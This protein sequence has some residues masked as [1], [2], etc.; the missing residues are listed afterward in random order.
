[1][2]IELRKL[3]NDLINTLHNSTACIEGK[4]VI[5]ELLAKECELKANEIISNQLQIITEKGEM[6][7]GT[8]LD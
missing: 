7:N 6:E 3:F 2:D 8:E 4:R 1:M 5:L